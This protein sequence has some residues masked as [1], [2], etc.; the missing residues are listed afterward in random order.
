MALVLGGAALAGAAPGQAQSPAAAAARPEI[1]LWRLDC[2]EIGVADLDSFSDT[3]AYVGQSRTLTASCYLIRSGDRYLLWDTGLPGALAGQ[4]PAEDGGYRMALRERV[5]DQL[6]RIGVQPGRSHSRDQPITTITTASRGLSARPCGSIADWEA[7]EPA[8][9][10]RLPACWTA[11]RVHRVRGAMTS[12]AT[13][14]SP[15]KMRGH[16]RGPAPCASASATGP[17]LLPA[18]LSFTENGMGRIRSSTRPAD[19][20]P[21]WRVQEIP[22]SARPAHIH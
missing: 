16:T 2:G 6:A 11:C 5:R 18:T 9:W 15:S 21:R 1:S 20:S 10:R 14:E 8:P 3:Y 7:T 17:V 22:Q 19:T 12:S 13:A 4:A